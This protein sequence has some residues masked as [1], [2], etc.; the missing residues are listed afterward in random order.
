MMT[1]SPLISAT[2]FSLATT[3][4]SPPWINPTTL[5]NIQSTHD[6]EMMLVSML[7]TIDERTMNGGL[8]EDSG[9]TE[10]LVSGFL[11]FSQILF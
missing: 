9:M 3:L 4:Q 8:I 6:P 7:V 11:P 1:S 10:M 5:I 2:N